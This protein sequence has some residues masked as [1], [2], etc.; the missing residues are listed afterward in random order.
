M[1]RWRGS[2]PP[3]AQDLVLQLGQHR[4]NA[5]PVV[6]RRQAVAQ[7]PPLETFT[8]PA[9]LRI[10]SRV[11]IRRRARAVEIPWFQAPVAPNPDFV[12]FARRR[13]QQRMWPRQP[14]SHIV[15]PP[16]P[17]QAAPVNPPIIFGGRT[18]WR[19]R[20][21]V[22]KGHIPMPLPDQPAPATSRAARRSV[23]WIRR[24]QSNRQ[25]WPQVVLLPPVWIPHMVRRSGLTPHTWPR[26]GGG[27]HWAIFPLTLANLGLPVP[28]PTR[29]LGQV[30]NSI[31]GTAPVRLLGVAVNRLLGSAGPNRMS[32]RGPNQLG[33][34]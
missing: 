26:R 1:R 7:A 13:V 19:L 9:C 31:A 17:Q 20:S 15:Q 5:P 6:R 33:G 27:R 2:E 30:A 4:R 16:W 11:V 29:I 34:D 25:P 8:A 3:Q 22:R 28:G 12:E 24:P 10:R 23:A 14:R 21:F 18:A 32:G